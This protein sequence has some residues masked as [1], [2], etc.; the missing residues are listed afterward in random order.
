MKERPIL[1][2][3]PM[4]RAI[5]EGR[6][7]V[8]RR[9]VKGM[10]QSPLDDGAYFDAYAGGPFWN[11]WLPDNRCM[12]PQIKC[13]YGQPGDR[14]WVKE[15]WAAPPYLDDTKPR[16]MPDDARIYYVADGE[17][18]LANCNKHRPCL[19]MQ[20][21]FS[22]ITL[23]IAEVRVERLQDITTNDIRAEG[24]DDRRTNPKMGK[25]HDASMRMAWEQ[26]WFSINGPD[27]WKANP[28]VWVIQSRRIDQ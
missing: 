1:F 27:S 26:L 18:G 10:P 20:K 15:T 6:K 11:W 24:V 4:V 2:S 9:V 28:W 21:R 7:T 19:F 12:L 17:L 3:A 8:T 5:L 23:E 22:R 16:D 13:P 25:R 14:L